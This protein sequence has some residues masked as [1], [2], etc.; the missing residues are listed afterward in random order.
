MQA[1]PRRDQHNLKKEEEIDQHVVRPYQSISIVFVGEV[2]AIKCLGPM[3][4][5]S[6]PESMAE[7]CSLLAS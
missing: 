2:T 7:C 1:I 3:M 6:S 4:E 5:N